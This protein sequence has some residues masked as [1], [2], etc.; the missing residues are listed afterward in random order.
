[1]QTSRPWRFCDALCGHGNPN[2]LTRDVGTSSLA[3]GCSGQLTA[4]QVERYGG[5]LP[6]MR[7]FDRPQHGEPSRTKA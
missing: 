1:M 3:Q 4:V 5:V 6:P 7:A 2:I